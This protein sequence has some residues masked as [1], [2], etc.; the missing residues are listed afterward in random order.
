MR[1]VE[2]ENY[3][4]ETISSIFANCLKGQCETLR[5]EPD[6]KYKFQMS[7]YTA[8]AKYSVFILFINERLVDCQP[9][10]KTLQNVFAQYLP[11]NEQLF[12][13]INL[14]LDPNNL[15]VNVHPTKHEVRFLYQ[16]E[17]I[18]KIQQ[19]FEEKFIVTSSTRTYYV[20]NLTLDS[21]VTSTGIESLST[22]KS[23][24]NDLDPNDLDSSK[25]SQ[26]NLLPYQLTRVDSRER[27]L[28]SYFH[29]TSLE[30]TVRDINE[31]TKK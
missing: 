2:N 29:S 31:E 16:D 5:I 12:V 18:A 25:K 9:L 28:D 3:L 27:K 30:K 7:A 1:C 19:T 17:I 15:D 13:Y 23:S 21:Y 10:K 6:E 24:Q 26:P 4:I 22:K 11:K 20:K 14:R 8:S